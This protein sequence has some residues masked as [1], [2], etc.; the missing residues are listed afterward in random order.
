[1][2]TFLLIMGWILSS[3][4]FAASSSQYISAENP[5][6]KDPIVLYYWGSDWDTLALEVIQ[7]FETRHNGS[8]GQPPIK[9]L[10]GQAACINNVDDP[11]RL[12]TAVAGGDPP[13]A[14]WFNRYSVSAM[15]ARG[16][17]E[18]LQP[19]YEHDLH[20]H[21][22]D[23]LTLKQEQFFTPCW[24]DVF[25]DG[26]MYAVPNDTDNRAL[27]YN[28]DILEKHADALI[29]AG[30]VDPENPNKVGPPRTWEQLK[31][32]SRILTE[33]DAQ[34]HLQRVGFIPNFGNSWFYI[35]SWLN[36]GSFLSAD[37]QTCTM[38]SRENIEALTYVTELYDLMGGAEAVSAF[39]SVLQGGDLDPLIS[40]K[41]AMR[42]D[43]DGLLNTIANTARSL[44]FGVV[45]APAPEGKRRL[46]WA[47]GWSWVIPKGA[48]HPQEAWEFLKFMASQRAYE[49]RANAM[50]QAARAAG[51]VFIPNFST[52]KDITTWALDYYL[53]NDPDIDEKFKVAKR[54]FH[55]GLAY[56]EHLPVSPVSPMLWTAQVR[57]ME[58]GIRHK[59]DP[60][61]NTRNAEY[62]LRACAEPVQRELDRLNH[63][64]HYPIVPYTPFVW[65]YGMLAPLAC[66]ILHG[67]FSRIHRGGIRAHGYFRRDLYA[68]YLFATP[69]IA[70]F[71]LFGGGPIL[72]SL[73]MSFCEYDVLSPPH[74]VG[75]KNYTMMLSGDPVFLKSLWNTFYMALSIPLGMAAG[76]G[77][78][79]LLNYEIK[80]IA[81]YRT[82]FYLPSIMPAV[83]ASI[84]WIWIFN[85]R[86]G[87]LNSLLMQIGLGGPAWLQDENWSK[88][89]LILMGLWGAGGS[90]VV[91][92]AGLKGIPRH[93][94]E[95]AE[96][97]G[98][99]A[100]RRFFN[101][102]LPML[103]PY[104]LFNLIM[105]LIG[106]FQI[107]TQAFVM[108]QGGP[109]DST[110]FYAY[111]LFN[112]AFRYMKMG[113]ASALAWVL[114][115]IIL[116]LTIIQ[117]R[118]S[119]RW[120]HYESEN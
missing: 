116:A 92:I 18:S 95:A 109:V 48:K 105:G 70:G 76:L 82:F 102:T 24:Q 99:G 107:F 91:W 101:I 69:W 15:A 4:A 12:L 104:I 36:G 118:L 49:I 83:A 46:G 85:P 57:A 97:D 90:M 52:R 11:Q 28:L 96:I 88:P 75:L 23:P 30:C 81:L 62:A 79:L 22:D 61:D 98:A 21:P 89:A 25:H 27:Y 63:P 10:M 119:K 51:N 111:H 68:G 38:A 2:R 42:I 40:G 103:S 64:I 26:Q 78:A 53:Y 74:F 29:A 17:F 43:G 80:G 55:D 94:Y 44:R 84:L 8:N 20:E 108:T 1:M 39:Q 106:T 86:E 72:F 56:A 110:L 16:A 115:V 6:K 117:L 7:D 50:R 33:Y 71:L 65:A 35:Y 41:V 5:S 100:L 58:E 13:D 37:G 73:L 93:L 9:I 120:V 112:N 31:A 60:Q 3:M 59:Y 114:F 67:Y 66:L 77:L 45:M 14:I 34:G 87:I 113:Y 47:A 54:I 19:Y 32:A